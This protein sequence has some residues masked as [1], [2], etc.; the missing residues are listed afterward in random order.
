MTEISNRRQ[1]ASS[2]NDD[3]SILNKNVNISS[4]ISTCRSDD[5]TTSST[6][7]YN[8]DDDHHFDDNDSFCGSLNESQEQEQQQQQQHQ[9]EASTTSSTTSTVTFGTVTIREYERQLDNCNTDV[10]LGL[11]IGWKFRQHGPIDVDTYNKYSSNK[12]DDGESYREAI[13]TSEEDRARILLACGYSRRA[14]RTAWVRKYDG[15]EDSVEMPY[16]IRSLPG[17]MMYSISKKNRSK[18]QKILQ[19]FAEEQKETDVEVWTRPGFPH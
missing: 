1:E 8:N 9:S 15:D 14:L 12:Q 17:R 16:A 3:Y 2:W 19:K 11:S 10:D 13:Y 4:T 5:S 6:N 18:K 7:D